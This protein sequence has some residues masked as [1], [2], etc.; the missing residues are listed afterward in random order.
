[1]T[2]QTLE[3][4]YNP[5]IELTDRVNKTRADFGDQKDLLL[6][7]NNVLASEHFEEIIQEI[8][9]CGFERG[10]MFVPSPCGRAR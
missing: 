2:K 9:D 1:M 4:V 7:D 6:M 5:Y 3:P 10:A 8:K